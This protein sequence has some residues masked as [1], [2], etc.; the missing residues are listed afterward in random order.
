[1]CRWLTVLLSLMTLAPLAGA[2]A[3][4]DRLAGR[5]EGRIAALQGERPTVAVF[6]R[7]GDGYTGRTLGLRPGVEIQLNDLK[8]EGD[9]LTAS[10]EVETPQAA[11]IIN[12][13]FK[14]EG[15][16]L[17]GRGA[18]DFGGQA[19]SFNIEL[20]RVSGD[21]EAPLTAG[22]AGR[23]SLRP[24][25]AQPQ[26]K[27]SP[28]YFAGQ[29]SFRYV[30]RESLLGL[31][32]RQGVVTFTKRPDGRTLDGR[33][34]GR[35]DAGTYTESQVITFLEGDKS[36]TFTERLANQAEITGRADWKI[37]ISIHYSVDP[38]R[39]GRRQVRI[40]RTIS[41]IAAHSFSVVEEISE[42]GAPFERLGSAVYSRAESK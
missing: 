17:R 40:R 4:P 19:L 42:D 32:P 33:V 7:V 16:V 8:L 10:A 30:G 22:A 35:T 37:P 11:V 36:F 5:W 20:K 18:L 26:Q 13:T 3:G 6:K 23:A 21:T 38:L 1:M 34:E 12:Y 24:V 2:Q 15:E 29:W 27:Q 28:D 39:I 41:I 31:A 25:V 14:L 9:Q